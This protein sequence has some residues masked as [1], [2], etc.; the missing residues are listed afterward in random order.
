MDMDKLCKAIAHG[1]NAVSG[2]MNEA[3]D[4]SHVLLASVKVAMELRND[5]DVKRLY[6]ERYSKLMN[7]LNED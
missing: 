3:C 6:G 2:H 1:A 5:A 4:I 7:E